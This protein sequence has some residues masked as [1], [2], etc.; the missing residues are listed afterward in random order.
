MM[1]GNVRAA[2]VGFV[3]PGFLQAAEFFPRGRIWANLKAEEPIEI[4][5]PPS[6]ATEE[7]P[8]SL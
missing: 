6:A 2:A 7:K 5:N 8:Q 3:G 1:R 4:Q